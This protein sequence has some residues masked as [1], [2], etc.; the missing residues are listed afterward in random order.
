MKYK[1]KCI[2]ISWESHTRSRSLAE[3]L[4]VPIFEIVSSSGKIKRYIFSIYKTISILYSKKPN[5]V[6]FQNPSIVL[7]VLMSMF[8]KISGLVV[9]MDAHNAGIYPIEGRS[10]FFNSIAGWLARSMDL[11][12]VTNQDLAE[13]VDASGG[14]SFVLTDPIPKL[15]GY[16]KNKTH[17]DKNID[18]NI[19]NLTLICSWSEDEPF[20]EVIEAASK[21]KGTVELSI[22]GR[23]PDFM[24]QRKLAPNVTL[25]GFLTEVDYFDLLSNSD[26]II[27]LTKRENCLVCGAYEAAALGIPCLLSDYKIS[28][29][30][31]I[32]GFRFTKNDCASIE[33]N[34]MECVGILSYLKLEMSNFK[35]S[36]TEK[37]EKTLKALQGKV[38]SISM[39]QHDS[40]YD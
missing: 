2:W 37:N 24:S 34:I 26:L 6:Y 22:T 23:F 38:E 32:E 40:E 39:S 3:A 33:R 19:V 1:E 29:S 13:T 30:V 28:K 4:G 27:D 8:R 21:L 20:L 35:K 25:S 18:N 17:Y 31:F 11:T 12:I 36:Y 16:L 5:V 10:K 9:V 15:N 14:R 7:A